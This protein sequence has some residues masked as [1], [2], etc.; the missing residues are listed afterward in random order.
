M[1]ERRAI[2]QNPVLRLLTTPTR[3]RPDA[4]G[5][6]PRKITD[7]QRYEGHRE[8]LLQRLEGIPK[9]PGRRRADHGGH[10]LLWVGMHPDS[11][12]SSH[13]PNDLF[14][15]DIG[16]TMQM[17]WRDGYVVEVTDQALAR[18]I[19]RVTAPTS[20]AQRCDIYRV[21]RLEVFSTVLA[22]GTRIADT[23]AS[24]PADESGLRRFNVRLARYQ[25]AEAQA[26][27]TARLLN[28]IAEDRMRLG[29]PD[30]NLALPP[31]GERWASLAAATQLLQPKRQLALGFYEQQSLRDLVLTGSVT[32]WE[33]V[34][35]LRPTVPGGGAEPPILLPDLEGDPIVGVIDGG[36]HAQRYESAVAWR[37]V[38]SLVQDSDAA[39]DHGNKVASVVVD[40]HLWSN[41]LQIP[42]LHCRLGVVQAVPRA[43]ARVSMLDSDTLR[44]I[45]RAFSDHPDTHVWN[46]SANLE[47]ECDAYEV[48]ELG[49]GLAE[50][51]R[52]QNK[53]L[54]VSA[55]NRGAGG[56]R[57]APPADCEAALVVSG[58]Q[59]GP[60]GLV[61]GPCGVS[62]VGLGPEGM[63][64]PETSWFSSLRV[65]GGAV[66]TGTSFAAPLIS[67][68]AAHTWQNLASPSADM[69]KALLLNASDL[70]HYSHE[71][72]FGSPVRP[73]LPWN[74]APNAAVIAWQQDMTYM[75]R[76]RW[77]G[78]RIP[79][80]LMK[81][82]RFN[83]R[84]KLVAVLAP[85]VDMEGHHYFQTRIEAGLYYKG[86][87]GGK[88]VNK[89]LAGCVNPLQLEADAR[90]DDNKWD[91]VRIYEKDCR[92]SHGVAISGAQPELL[93]GARLYWRDTFRYAPDF[94]RAQSNKATFVVMLESRDPESDAYNEFRR[95]MA[96]N[97]ES[98]VVE[99]EIEVDNDA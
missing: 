60:D 34:S 11:L 18:L 82:G 79:P 68:L 93:V 65:L 40:A 45:E 69:V 84:A 80:S 46:L 76:Y 37:Q 50:I 47:R 39:R 29:Q 15:E 66:A 99:Q 9:D 44:Y 24:A 81:N 7:R 51:A 98:A 56:A 63:L 86:L 10:Y 26:S 12:A 71:L 20:G 89:A 49:H 64:K 54:V 23:W 35:G 91:P 74:C 27:V 57:I 90:R 13:T 33:P 4:R 83:G 31:S 28:L 5:K 55:G 8:Q 38:P 36:Y 2:V 70:D 21:A 61:A 41:Q 30:G 22:E 72:G 3:D 32:R 58:R 67:R 94:M 43:G 75:Q 73:E 95:I 1:V 92:R 48:S 16:A 85:H 62:R 6:D 14:S 97:V 42:A 78:I 87:V 59:H 77:T 96:E 52:R 17:A 19:G 53:L 88:V 25:K